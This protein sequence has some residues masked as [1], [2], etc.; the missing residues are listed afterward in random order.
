MQCDVDS[1]QCPCLANAIGRTCDRCLENHYPYRDVERDV[2][3]LACSCN[4]EGS[5][6]LQCS[7]AED[8]P[9]LPQCQCRPGVDGHRCDQCQAGFW[10]LTSS[11][12]QPCNCNPAGSQ[13]IECDEMTGQ[14]MSKPNVMGLKADT[15]KPGYIYLHALNPDGCIK[16]F[17][18][19]MSD[20]CEPADNFEVA[21]AESKLMESDTDGWTFAHGAMEAAENDST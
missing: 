8:N 20:V 7:A 16:C 19:G 14:C 17:G 2:G 12:C 1:G 6:S 15:C 4:P 13:G 9:S 21:I 10:N 3:C 5:V 11:G 18:N